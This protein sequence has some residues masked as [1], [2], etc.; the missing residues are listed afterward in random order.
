RG[1]SIN[2][3]GQLLLADPAHN[4]ILYYANSPTLPTAAATPQ[5]GDNSL[6]PCPMR[7][8][9]QQNTTPPQHDAALQHGLFQQQQA[10]SAY[11]LAAPEDIL[12][13]SD[14]SLAV[15][16]TGH[17]RLLIYSWPELRLLHQQRWPGSRPVA[18]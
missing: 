5:T 17:S 12:F 10:P 14:G 4:Q 2:P 13:L 8:L 9:W 16:D 18:L 15:A 3:Q 1:V 6:T 11:V 7:P